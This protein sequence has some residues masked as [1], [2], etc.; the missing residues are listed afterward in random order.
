V[1]GRPEEFSKSVNP[2]SLTTSNAGFPKS[3]K[4]DSK[5]NRKYKMKESQKSQLL[6]NNE[7]Q[8]TWKATL[9][10]NPHATDPS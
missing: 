3:W 8:K 6:K 9:P 5:K 4:P 2:E 1:A 10:D 7:I